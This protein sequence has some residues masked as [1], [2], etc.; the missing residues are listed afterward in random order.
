MEASLESQRGRQRSR[1]EGCHSKEQAHRVNL[2]ATRYRTAPTGPQAARTAEAPQPARRPRRRVLRTQDWLPMAYA[3]ARL[4]SLE[5]GVSLFQ[6]L[7]YRRY[8]GEAAPDD[9]AAV[10]E[11][12]RSRS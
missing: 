7:A 1:Q 6:S 5:D 8:L 12:S 9:T 11:A 10:A 2:I 3:P 4:P